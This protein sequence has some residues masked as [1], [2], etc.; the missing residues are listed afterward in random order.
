MKR[1]RLVAN[2]AVILLSMTLLATVAIAQQNSPQ[3]TAYR[4]V[5]AWGR[6]ADDGRNDGSGRDGS[7]TGPRNDGR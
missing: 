2:T 7:S 4:T 1:T 3:A 5:A 6:N